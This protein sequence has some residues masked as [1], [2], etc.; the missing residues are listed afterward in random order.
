MKIGIAGL[1]RMGTA[2]AL[3]LL[4]G[5]HQ[6]SV[7]NRT[8]EKTAAAVAAGASAVPTPA[9]LA[10]NSEKIITILTNATAMHAVYTAKDGLLSRHVAGKLFVEMSTV[11]AND[12]RTL[13]A[14]VKATGARGKFGRLCGRHA[15]SIHS[16]A[17]A[18]GTTVSQSRAD[19]RDGRRCQ[20]EVGSEPAADRVLAVAR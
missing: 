13:E 20:H 1:G 3:R 7:W 2:I 17:T 18:A 12:H 9:A 11:R 6:V 15:R 10:A 14:K 19:R 4:D 5:G 8:A 16:G